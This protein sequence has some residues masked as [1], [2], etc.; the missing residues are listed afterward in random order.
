MWKYFTDKNTHRYID[1]LSQLVCAYNNSVHRSIRMKPIEVTESTEQQA[2]ENL[3]GTAKRKKLVKNSPKVG[4]YVRIALNGHIFSR[5]YT[6]KWSQEVFVITEKN[7]YPP[8]IVFKLRDLS[9]ENTQG[10][11]YPQEIQRVL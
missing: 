8:Y 5:G 1:V 11:F 7:T 10:K 9:G 3:Y 6:H 2:L 4:D